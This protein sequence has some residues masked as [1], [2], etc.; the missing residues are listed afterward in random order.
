VQR[1]ANVNARQ[2]K[3]PRDGNR[4]T[5]NRIGSTPFLLAAKSADV[6]LMRVLLELGAD[7]SIPTNNGTTALMAAA[8]VGIW[9]PGE[10]PGTHDEALAAVKLAFEVGGGRVNDIDKE[11]ETAL[12]GAVYRGGAIPVIQF[13]IEKGA[14]FD[15]KNKRGWTPLT[16]ADGV[17]YTPAVLKRYPEAAALIRAAMRARGLAVPES[18][19]PG[20]PRI[21]PVAATSTQTAGRTIWDGVFTEAQ[22]SRGQRGYVQACARCHADDLLGSSN[23]PALVGQPFFARFDRSTAD[24]VMQTIRQTM[25]QEAPDSLGAEAYVDIVSYLFKANGSPAGAAELTADRA[26]LQQVLVTAKEVR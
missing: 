21:A 7:P 25:P 5:L 15:V 19:Q 26:N 4:N 14:A 22:A 12:H 10:N 18:T 11:G 1:G 3:E 23:A 6:P 17:E 13:L 9:A 16:A 20:G 24:D 2:K 8:G